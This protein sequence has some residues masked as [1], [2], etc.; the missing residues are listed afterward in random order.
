VR[1]LRSIFRLTKKSVSRER[2]RG[3]AVDLGTALQAER[4]RVRFPIHGL[5]PSDRS[6]AVGST[7]PLTEM[8]TRDTSW[9]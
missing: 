5:N 3:G 1:I 4:S 8:S 9:G 2:L 6:M 7:P